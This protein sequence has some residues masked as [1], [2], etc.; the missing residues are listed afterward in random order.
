MNGPEHLRTWFL[1]LNGY[2]TTTNFYAHHRRETLGEVDVTAV[3][4]RHSQE[5]HFEDSKALKIPS[6]KIDV[7][8]AEAKR[9]LAPLVI[10]GIHLR[11]RP[12]N[13]LFAELVLP[14]EKGRRSVC[15]AS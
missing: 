5:L 15:V 7:V 6:A 1:R 12:W 11:N 4:F 2:L 3:R 8:L 13:M 14:L 9:G 10:S